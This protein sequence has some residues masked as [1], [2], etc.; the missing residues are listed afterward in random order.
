MIHGNSGVKAGVYMVNNRQSDNEIRIH[1]SLSLSSNNLTGKVSG[2]LIGWEEVAMAADLSK[3]RY[4]Q[5]TIGAGGAFQGPTEIQFPPPYIRVG[6]TDASGSFDFV[7]EVYFD[8]N[9]AQ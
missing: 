6:H 7:V 4:H 9:L 1:G 3:Y 5:G 8:K 2:T